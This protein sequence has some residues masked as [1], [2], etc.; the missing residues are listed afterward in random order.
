M[1]EIETITR[2]WGNSL[3]VTLPKEIVVR[4]HIYE[5]Q[6]V[7]VEIKIVADIRKLR[8]LVHFKRSTQMIK[9]EM[10]AGWK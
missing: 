8:G 9:E 7:V 3:G 10:R 4:E 1:V 2:K 5:N 6:R